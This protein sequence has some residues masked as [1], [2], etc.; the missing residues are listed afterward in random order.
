LKEAQAQI[1]GQQREIETLK[2]TLKELEKIKHNQYAEI[3]ALQTQVCVVVYTHSCTHKAF[4][5]LTSLYLLKTVRS[6]KRRRRKET[7]VD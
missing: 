1:D 4:R 7:I 5:F 3:K 6:S 2:T